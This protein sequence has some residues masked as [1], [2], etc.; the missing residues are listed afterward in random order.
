MKKTAKGKYVKAATIK[1]PGKTSWT[2]S[3]LAKKF[4]GKKAYFKV[5][6]YTDVGNTIYYGK[7]S[8]VRSVRIKK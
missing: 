1:K 2:C 8:K 6:T 5:R 7:W 4:I 3:R